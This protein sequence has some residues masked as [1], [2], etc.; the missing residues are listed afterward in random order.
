MSDDAVSVRYIH[1]NGKEWT[2]DVA[3]GLSVME[4]AINEGI[5]GITAEC[6]GECVCATCHVYVDEAFL[7]A[8]PSIEEQEDEMLE[9]TASPRQP[10]SRLSCQIRVVPGL[11]GVTIRLPKSQI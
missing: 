6:G 9:G 11:S 8:L 2:I 3:P 10:N 1:P 4:A 5:P 7:A